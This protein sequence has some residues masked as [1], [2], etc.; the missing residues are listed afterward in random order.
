MHAYEE[1]I[2]TSLSGLNEF[3]YD[4]VKPFLMLIQYMVA[5][6]AEHL[7]SGALD[8]ILTNFLDCVK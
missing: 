3:D 7:M 5:K 1:L 6:P 2:R 8:L 4:E